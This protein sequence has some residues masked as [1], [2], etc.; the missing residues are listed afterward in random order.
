[1]QQYIVNTPL[2]AQGAKKGE[3]QTIQPGQPVELEDDE[4]TRLIE[5]G[6]IRKPDV[7]D[8]PAANA[9]ATTK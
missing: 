3:F 2:K 5:C 6:A 1:M 4:A 7:I 9:K 8:A